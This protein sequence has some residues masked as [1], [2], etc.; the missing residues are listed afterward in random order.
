MYTHVHCIIKH[1]CWTTVYYSRHDY[2]RCTVISSSEPAHPLI[3]VNKT[4]LVKLLKFLVFFFY[5]R[6]TMEIVTWNGKY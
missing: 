1:N 5:R 3:V 6:D 4:F 2:L